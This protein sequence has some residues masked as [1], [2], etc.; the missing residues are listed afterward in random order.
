[1]PELKIK[2]LPPIENLMKSST[3]VFAS[4]IAALAMFSQPAIATDIH[5]DRQFNIDNDVINLGT[6]SM[7]Y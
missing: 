1:L 3:Q 6:I 5:A 4:L 2:H 7:H